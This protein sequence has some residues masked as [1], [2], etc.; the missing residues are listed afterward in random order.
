MV[1]A[2]GVTKI[3]PN[4]FVALRDVTFSIAP[5]ELAFLVG[6]SGAGKTSLLRLLIRDIVPTDGELFI[7]DT[8]LS[9]LKPK[10]IP[11]LRRQ[12]GMIFQDY[13]LLVERNVRENLEFIL[14]IV[15][16]PSGEWES[17]IQSVLSKVGLPDK[18]ELFPAQLSG[19]EL[20]RVAI[21][22]ALLLEPPLVLADEPTGNLDSKTA[23]GIFALFAELNMSGTTILVATH[24]EKAIKK[25]HGRRLQLVEGKLEV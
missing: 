21:A 7:G 24:D 23:G 2:V 3:F 5:G 14:E 11:A 17:K 12:I 13:R 4:G 1:R 9:E 8:S 18:A 10:D 16:V 20:Q 22:R 6:E 15:G 19:G 25:H